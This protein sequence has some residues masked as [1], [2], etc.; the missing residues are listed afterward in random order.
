MKALFAAGWSAI[1]VASTAL[2]NDKPDDLAQVIMPRQ[3]PA[4]RTP[5]APDSSPPVSARPSPAPGI[6]ER[7]KQTQPAPAQ[8]TSEQ[9]WTATFSTETRYYSWRN[10]FIPPD[11]SGIGPGRGWEVYIPFAMQL[12]GKPVDDLNV[13][14]VVR[15]GWVKAAQTTTGL[16]GEVATSTDTV[17]SV[18]A[19]YLGWQGLQPFIAL[20]ANLPTGKSALFG[21]SVNA[22]MDP[23]LVEIS[24]FGEGYNLGPS[25]GFNVPIAGSLLF[26]A[27]VGYTW[28]GPFDRESAFPT[29]P[30]GVDPDLVANLIDI[31]PTVKINPG[32][33]TTV[34]G[35]VN[36]GT[37]SFAVGLTGSAS[38]ESPTNVRDR[39][40]F[41]PGLRYLLSLQSSYKWPEK[42]GVTELTAAAAHSN[43]N[44]LVFE[45]AEPT[46]EKF[47]SNS[48]VYRVGLQHLFPVD[49]FQ[50]GP[51]VS[52]L[53]RDHNGYNSTTLQ[54]V[55]QKTRWAAGMLAQYAPNATVTLNARVEHVWTRE[56]ESPAEDGAKLDVLAKSLI[57]ASTVPVISGTAWQTSFGINVKL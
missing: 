33:N 29:L 1:A 44:K 12:T 41:K 24:T 57:P 37:G 3:V 10:N 18:D 46:S 9:R 35:A 7:Q 31:I 54:F 4:Q 23:D 56:N 15:G 34:T 6:P 48:N 16:A 38:W 13:D 25:F 17:M 52:F 5:A 51:T 55:P 36:Y 49:Q 27:S 50:I 32:E 53:Y 11:T 20:S 22:R 19:T 28:R 8:Q 26:T 2:A 40:S 21:T 45:I 39:P 14:F 47:N 42:W 30:P 43:R